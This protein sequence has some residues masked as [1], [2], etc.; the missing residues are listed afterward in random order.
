LTQAIAFLQAGE[1]DQ[2]RKK[3]TKALERTDGC[4]LEGT[5]DG[6]GPGRDVVTDCAA[7]AKLY[8]LLTAA[9][10]ALAEKSRR[11]PPVTRTFIRRA[12][13]VARRQME[14]GAALHLAFSSSHNGF[15]AGVKST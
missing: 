2:A 10:D 7:Q 15:D 5:P 6:N 3:L 11:A 12:T 14:R 1:F 4:A 13:R 8:D 9:L